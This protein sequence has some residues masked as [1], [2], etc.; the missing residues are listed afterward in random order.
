MLDTLVDFEPVAR[1][2]KFVDGGFRIIAFAPRPIPDQVVREVFE[3]SI[4]NHEVAARGYQGAIEPQ[5][6]KDVL[7][8]VVRVENY[9]DP[10]PASSPLLNLLEHRLIGR[11][12]LDHVDS[13]RHAVAFEHDAV[14][15]P[16]V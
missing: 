14:R 4:K 9:H 1:P 16:A 15:D 7:V 12:S 3:Q 2:E 11:R 8:S 5:F 13:R 10:S 6:P